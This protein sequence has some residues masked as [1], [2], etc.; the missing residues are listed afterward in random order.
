MAA[1]A[2]QV[3]VEV[4]AKT[5]QATRQVRAYVDTVDS[6]M[7]RVEGSVDRA[8]NAVAR[9]AATQRAA[10]QQLG[11]QLSDVVAQAS[12]GTSAFVILA[13]QGGQTAAALSSFGGTVGKVATFMSGPF[14]AAILGAVTVLGLLAS[15]SDDAEKKQRKQG[16]AATNLRE[17]IDDLNEASGANVKTQDEVIRAAE[18]TAKKFLAQEVAT[19]RATAALLEQAI[20]EQR[21]L[22][23]RAQAPGQRGDIAAIGIP[24]INSTVAALQAK[25]AQT[26][27]GIAAA[28]QALRAKTAA[29]VSLDVEERLD[30]ARKALRKFENEEAAAR[31]RFARGE[32]KTREELD[33]AIEA[34]ARRRDAAIEAARERANQRSRRPKK[35][36]AEDPDF[37]KRTEGL[38][39]PVKPLIAPEVKAPTDEEVNAALAPVLEILGNVPPIEPVDLNKFEDAISLAKQFTSDLS[40][41]LADA[42]VFGDDLGDTL[43][44]S[45]KRAAAALLE[46]KILSL[47]D[48]ARSGQSGSA[49]SFFNIAASFLGGNTRRASGGDVS[50]GTIYRVNDGGRGIEGFQPAG[51]GKVIP[52]GRM[53]AARSSNLTVVSSPRFD[54]RGA[55]MTPELLA[56]INARIAAS[57]RRAVQTAIGAAAQG[58]PGRLASYQAL[59]T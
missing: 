5:D 24:I 21:I 33:A 47:L 12:S 3:V 29:V 9:S 54:L 19:R 4:L 6:G 13:Q 42:I 18:L 31:A 14:G 56:D 43:S 8:D 32:I 37:I 55:V 28:E 44:N 59:G 1:I 36:K 26:E 57:E 49:G 11:F 35:E 7:R 58:A 25:L 48:P 50:A 23:I 46:S 40:R 27:A 30:P 34:S 22:G 15:K 20:E 38:D 16:D 39:D 52:L 10:Y 17:A 2:D 41:G 51:S 53:N 45:F